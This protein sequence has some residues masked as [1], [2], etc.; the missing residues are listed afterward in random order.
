M[1]N[2]TKHRFGLTTRKDRSDAVKQS[3]PRNKWNTK[4]KVG[5]GKQNKMLN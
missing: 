1:N 2:N 4:G 3:N 5:R